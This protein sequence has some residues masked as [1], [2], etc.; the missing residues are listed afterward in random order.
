MTTTTAPPTIEQLLERLATRGSNSGTTA[1]VASEEAHAAGW[2]RPL[3]RGK[4][5]RGGDTT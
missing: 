1:G 5:A 3:P 2:L 4:K